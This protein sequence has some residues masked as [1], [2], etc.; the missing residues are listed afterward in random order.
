MTRRH[1]RSIPFR[2][3]FC[4]R[5][6]V[7]NPLC[8]SNSRVPRPSDRR[9]QST[10][11]R[12]GRAARR[13]TQ[14][15]VSRSPERTA[16]VSQA[17]SPG[18][19]VGTVKTKRVPTS[20]VNP[21]D[22]IN[23]CSTTAGI[24]QRLPY[25]IRTVWVKPADL[26]GRRTQF[27]VGRQRRPLPVAAVSSPPGVPLTYVRATHPELVPRH[28]ECA[29]SMD[30]SY[31]SVRADANMAGRNAVS[32]SS[33]AVIRPLDEASMSRASCRPWPFRTA[34]ARWA[35]RPGSSPRWGWPAIRPV[36]AL[37]PGRCRGTAACPGRRPRGR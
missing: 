30:F 16:K 37:C 28:L 21:V 33:N 11:Q 14:L 29:V 3:I 5:S 9:A 22:G 26:N 32:P 17:I 15:S 13:S 6:S 2:A 24:G 10:I 35:V 7:S 23:H 4:R 19:C 36:R 1:I 25:V 27:T 12:A 31:S 8:L 34:G 18:G 20:A